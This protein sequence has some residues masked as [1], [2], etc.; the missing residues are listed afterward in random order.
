MIPQPPKLDAVDGPNLRR[1]QHRIERLRYHRACPKGAKPL[2]LVRLSTGGD[3]DHWNG[4]RVVPGA[5]TR[6]C[7]GPVHVRHHHIEQNQVGTPSGR[8]DDRL[9]SGRDC[10]NHKPGIEIERDVRYLTDVGFIVYV[11]NPHV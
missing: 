1:K 9:P 10:F 11:K 2:D 6:Q 3:E 4:L 8:Y 5:Q 7:G